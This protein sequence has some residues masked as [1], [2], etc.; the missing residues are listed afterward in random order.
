MDRAAN[1]IEAFLILKEHD[2]MVQYLA[3]YAHVEPKHAL[4]NTH[5]Q[6]QA[7]GGS[8]STAN[9]LL[10]YGERDLEEYFEQC[11]PP[12]L[13]VEIED[14]WKDLFNVADAVRRIHDFEKVKAGVSQEYYGYPDNAP[15][16]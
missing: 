5:F 12:I 11:L 10:E 2:G 4:T 14:F 3:E 6:P 9:I 7:S 16:R 13:Q 15:T 8:V 1:E